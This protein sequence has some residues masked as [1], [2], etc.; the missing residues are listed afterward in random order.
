[1]HYTWNFGVIWTYRDAFVRGAVTTVELTFYAVV[2]GAGMGLFIGLAR[3]SHRKILSVPA[4]IF[5]ETFRSTPALVQLVWIYYCLPILT[6]LTF[7]GFVSVLI[8]LSLHTT[9]YMGEIFRGGI[10][11]IDRGQYHAAMSIGMTHTQMMRRIVLPQALRR[12]IPPFMNELANLVKLTTL[13]SV[14]AVE[15][16]QYQ[17]A[18]LITQT[19][20]PLEIF[21]FLAVMFAAIIYPLTLI[22]RYI[23]NY[24][25]RKK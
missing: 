21:T 17:A 8:G 12:V 23:E 11:S 7:S 25:E 2:I 22:A 10:R 4:S 18:N 24:Y 19:F 5:V 6:G 15:E 3:D 20:R 16:L 9:A 14:L 13:A 1:V